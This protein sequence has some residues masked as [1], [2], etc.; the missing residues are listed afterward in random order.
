MAWHQDR[1]HKKKHYFLLQKQ[2]QTLRKSSW[3][4]F[5]IRWKP[6]SDVR[7]FIVFAFVNAIQIFTWFPLDFLHD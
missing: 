5:L 3:D 7:D 1:T 6:D 4:Q 2:S